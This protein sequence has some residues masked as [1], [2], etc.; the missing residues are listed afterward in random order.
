MSEEFQMK[1]LQMKG[2]TEKIQGLMQGLP[3]SKR[4][5]LVNLSFKIA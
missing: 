5:E 4:K 1:D 2:L 3:K